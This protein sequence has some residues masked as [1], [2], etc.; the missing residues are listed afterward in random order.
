MTFIIY[1]TESFFCIAQRDK[2][3]G[4][5]PLLL[6]FEF[7]QRNK[8][9]YVTYLIGWDLAQPQMKNKPWSN[10]AIWNS[11]RKILDETYNGLVMFIQYIADSQLH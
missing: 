9:T 3:S 2:N 4:H 7:K 8:I 6:M 11:G 5:G 1:S 10:K